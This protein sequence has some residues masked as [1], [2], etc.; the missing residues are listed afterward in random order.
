MQKRFCVS[1]AVVA[2]VLAASAAQAQTT[3][4]DSWS[5]AVDEQ[6]D[7]TSARHSRWAWLGRAGG[8]TIYAG[9]DTLSGPPSARNI[10]TFH[11]VGVVGEFG[12][13]AQHILWQ[14]DCPA[15]LYRRVALQSL[16]EDLQELA[17]SVN[18]EPMAPLPEGNSIAGAVAAIACDGK[19]PN[20]VVPDRATA[21]AQARSPS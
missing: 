21:L 18:S 3:P 17:A 5:L 13:A 11:I 15:R 4:S 12:L 10:M 6:P 2:T 20:H 14:F 1:L 8:N 19:A 16:G 9:L 7:F